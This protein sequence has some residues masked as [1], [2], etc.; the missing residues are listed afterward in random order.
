MEGELAIAAV[1][2]NKGL[3]AAEILKHPERWQSLAEYLRSLRPP[4]YRG[5]INEQIAEEGRLLYLENCARCHG[6]KESYDETLILR[7]QI[8]TDPA[9]VLAVTP[10]LV[11]VRRSNELARHIKPRPRDGYIPPPLDG[12]WC[13]G[14]F[15]HNG[16]VP[17]LEDLLRPV[18]E[19]PIRFPLG[20]DTGYDRHRLGL[21]YEEERGA[22]GRRQG[23]R[24]SSQQ[25]LFEV[26]AP[27]N[28]NAGH[29]HGTN[30][31]PQER[32]ALLEFLKKR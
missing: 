8:G 17:T 30:L 2:F 5:P 32:R 3:S 7:E 11:R 29:L 21:L 10:D 9:R 14:P 22:D 24:N 20:G 28:S 19:R 23:K 31:S 13:R 4:V 1:E 27:G 25:Q 16:S 12:I 6:T 15:L 26:Q 18:V